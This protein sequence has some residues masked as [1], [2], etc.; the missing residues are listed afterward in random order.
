MKQRAAKLGNSAQAR[1]GQVD[2][3]TLLFGVLDELGDIVRRQVLAAEQG[4]WNVRNQA[5]VG[6]VLHRIVGQL[7][8]QHRAGRHA[9]VVNQIGV[10]IGCGTGH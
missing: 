4:H 3:V 2:L 10:A 9:V 5:D 1:V 6:E 7:A 8:I